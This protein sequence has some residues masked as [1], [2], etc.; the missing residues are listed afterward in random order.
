[1]SATF[2]LL[3]ALVAGYFVGAVPLGLLVSKGVAGIDIRHYGTGNI[4]AANIRRNIG[5]LPAMVVAFGVFLQGLAPPLLA[6]LLGVPEAAVAAAAVGTVIGYGWPV[7]LKFKGG[8]GVGIA[9]GA[10]LALSPGGFVLLLTTYALGALVR[11][12]ALGV[13][14]GFVVYA[15]FMLYSADSVSVKVTAILLVALIVIRRLE[16]ITEEVGRE[17][18][19]RVLLN[20]LLFDWRPEQRLNGPIEKERCR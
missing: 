4:G 1:M 3:S 12:I 10:A 5:L 17:D 9:T 19:T 14:L 2:G 7:F 16:G 6:R 15:A 18:F 8:R 13:L 11:H 20:R